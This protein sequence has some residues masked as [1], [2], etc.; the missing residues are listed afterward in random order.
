LKIELSKRLK[1]IVRELAD[2][3]HERELRKLLL[4]LADA[5][6]E[7]RK[8]DRD[9]AELLEELDRLTVPRR[10][11]TQRYST[12]DIA[13]MMVAYAIVAGLLREDEVPGDVLRA[14]DRP[15]AFYR[16]GLSDGTVSME[17]ED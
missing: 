16:K 9:T 1:A 15:I 8:G 13:P 3:A 12:T 6:A 10:R 14:I 2:K 7:W 17:E 11:L 4:P 5:F